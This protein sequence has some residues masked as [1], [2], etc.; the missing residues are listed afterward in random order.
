MQICRRSELRSILFYTKA[1]PFWS[2][3]DAGVWVF[4][5][6]ADV[7]DYLVEKLELAGGDATFDG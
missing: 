6:E 3:F 2:L 1:P 7:D 5:L 4:S